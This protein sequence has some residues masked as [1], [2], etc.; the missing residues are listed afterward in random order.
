[1]Q[2]A[3]T[4]CT[5]AILSKAAQWQLV[6]TATHR[7]P[8]EAETVVLWLPVSCFTCYLCSA[9]AT[10]RDNVSA[11]WNNFESDA[12][13]VSPHDHSSGYSA[14]TDV[15]S[16]PLLT[17]PS[18]TARANLNS[19]LGERVQATSEN[20]SATMGSRC[21]AC[22]GRCVVRRSE[23]HVDICAGFTGH[24]RKRSVSARR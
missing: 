11:V 3:R 9:M 2:P 15:P 20:G 24:R 18:Y 17:P 23:A 1:M 10:N 22:A 7:S 13:P 21:S 4:P 5:R 8:P 14:T 12:T 6:A 19:N 16:Q